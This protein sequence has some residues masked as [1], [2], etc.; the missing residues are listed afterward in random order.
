MVST[1]GRG[2]PWWVLGACAILAIGRAEAETDPP[3]GEP[4]L[5]APPSTGAPAA[6]EAGYPAALVARPLLLPSGGVE[7]GVRLLAY[8]I[9]SGGQ[10]YTFASLEPRVRYGLGRVELEG[11]VGLFLFQDVPGDGGSPTDPDR[12]QSVF[13]AGRYGLTPDRSVG[14]ELTAG[15]LTGDFKTYL[16][17][18]VL[19]DKAHLAPLTAIEST[20]ALGYGRAQF[21]SGPMSS[22][23]SW[24]S[25]ELRGRLEAQVTSR[26]ALE[27][28]AR[29]GYTRPLGDDD[30]PFF[31]GA[32]LGF[33]V[34]V[35]ALAAL[36]PSVDVVA[37]IDIVQAGSNLSSKAFTVGVL[38][39]RVP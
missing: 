35:G 36:T 28:R 19:E 37:A 24:L 38:A 14:V 3:G 15:G 13:V 6:T 32:T 22:S 31:G 12:L 20:V 39:R 25:L 11:A 9:E 26:L 16:P 33:D 8:R 2:W 23:S 27:G 18:L 30:T 29:L 21:D 7:G 4:P 1:G 10:A 34:G 17:A 5:G